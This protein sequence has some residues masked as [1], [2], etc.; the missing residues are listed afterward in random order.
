MAAGAQSHKSKG[1]RAK[2]LP[3]TDE[4]REWMGT[5]NLYQLGVAMGID[6]SRLYRIQKGWETSHRK[7]RH[8]RFLS[9]DLADRI[10]LFA[11][12]DKTLDDFWP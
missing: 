12:D 2:R 1:I 6:E 7:K 11:K 10:L 5:Q 4:F 3:L 9:V 8:I